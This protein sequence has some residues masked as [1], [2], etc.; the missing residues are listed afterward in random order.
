MF[1]RKKIGE[2]N[3]QGSSYDSG[4]LGSLLSSASQGSAVPYKKNNRPLHSAEM[5]RN[6]GKRTGKSGRLEAERNSIL[7][8]VSRLTGVS[9]PSRHYIFSRAQSLLVS[10]LRLEP[11]FL[12]LR[13]SRH[14]GTTELLDHSSAVE[15]HIPLVEETKCESSRGGGVVEPAL[16]IKKLNQITI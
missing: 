12:P 8:R 15:P 9:R 14:Q 11:A 2:R 5:R 6:K 3:S 4:V 10:R 16:L 13:P 7:S 1:Q